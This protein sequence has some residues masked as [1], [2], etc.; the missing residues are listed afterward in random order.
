MSL[1]SLRCHRRNWK[2]GRLTESGHADVVCWGGGSLGQEGGMGL[3]SCGHRFPWASPFTLCCPE[4]GPRAR[5][6]PASMGA[7]PGIHSRHQAC[8][9]HV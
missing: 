4:P 2:R 9:A 5:P 3:R 6:A 8:L 1:L 7:H